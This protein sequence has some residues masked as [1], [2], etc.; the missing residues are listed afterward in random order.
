MPGSGGI[1]NCGSPGIAGAP[2]NPPTLTAAAAADPT[3]VSTIFVVDPL[4]S[5]TTACGA[6]DSTVLGGGLKNGL[7]IN[8]FTYGTGSVGPAKDD[9]GN[10]YAVSRIRA[11][12]HHELFF[13]AER[14]VNNGDSHMDFEFMQWPV[15]RTGTCSGKLS[16]HRT[17]GDLLLAVDFTNGGTLA[18]NSLYQWHCKADPGPQPATGTVCDPLGSK[19]VPHY[20][21]IAPLPGTLT[22]LVNAAQIDCGGWVCRDAITG[23][24]ALVA[25][26]DL[27]EGAIDLGVLP[28]AICFN[29]ML[30]HTRTSAPFTAGLKDFSGPTAFRTCRGNV[31]PGLPDTGLVLP[32]GPLYSEPSAAPSSA[33]PAGVSPPARLMVPSL[34]I[35]ARVQKVGLD[36]HGNVAAPG[37]LMDA[38]WYTGSAAPGDPGGLREQRSW[39]SHHH[40]GSDGAPADQGSRGALAQ[41]AVHRAGA[42]VHRTTAL[43]LRPAGTIAASFGESACA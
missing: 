11:D 5:E 41:A 2:P 27:M 6:G 26:N 3:I 20:Q 19:P 36:N 40:R 10:I 42:A 37:A 35:D 12:G 15:S 7:D 13:G 31:I 22:F 43:T 17:Q 28:F 9:L 30:P 34:G 16:G 14:R 38:G 1:F 32:D 33:L 29:A 8:T 39:R 18:G 21:L 25:P 4:S 23:D 24:P